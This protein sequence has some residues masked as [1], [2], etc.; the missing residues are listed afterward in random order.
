VLEASGNR[1]IPTYYNWNIQIISGKYKIIESYIHINM[2][3][4][5]YEYGR[6]GKCV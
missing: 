6:G 1:H 3:K 5:V 4:D 2:V